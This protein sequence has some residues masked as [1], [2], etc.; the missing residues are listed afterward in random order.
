MASRKFPVATSLTTLALAALVLLPSQPAKALPLRC[1]VYLALLGERNAERALL[2][3]VESFELGEWESCDRIALEA[4]LNEELL[5]KAYG[6]ALLWAES[7][8]KLAAK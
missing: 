3:W 2:S 1:E 8:M 4:G 5:P 6:E 7:N